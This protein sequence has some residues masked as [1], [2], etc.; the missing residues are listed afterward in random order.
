MPGSYDIT[1]FHSSW[2]L[3]QVS[4][5]LSSSDVMIAGIGGLAGAGRINVSKVCAKHYNPPDTLRTNLLVC[6][7][8]LRVN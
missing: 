1:A 3:E 6:T 5:A 4:M 2:T 8:V 7:V